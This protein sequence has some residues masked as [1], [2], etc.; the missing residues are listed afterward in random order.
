MQ[1]KTFLKCVALIT[2]ILAIVAG[3]GFGLDYFKWKEVGKALNHFIPF[4]MLLL[5]GWTC[6]ILYLSARYVFYNN[7]EQAA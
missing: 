6:G 4:G 1:T 3:I 5:I 2:T 7:P